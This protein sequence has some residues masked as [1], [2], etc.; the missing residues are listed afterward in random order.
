M[1]GLA[2]LPRFRVQRAV[3]EALA[4]DLGDAGDITTR[5]TVPADA[6]WLAAI[7]ARK[8]GRIA[9]LD[10]ARAAFA[11]LD[12]E[13]ECDIRIGD[14]EDAQAG[15]T[16]AQ[17]RASAHAL[18]SG[19]RVA[20][21]F[22]GHLSGIATQTARFVDAIRGTGAQICCTR[23]TTP[24]LRAF[25]KYAVRA[26]GGVNHRFGLYDAV[27]IKDNHI[28]AAGGIA[29]AIERARDAAGH[30]V[31]IEVEVDTLDQLKE[32]LAH[33]IDAVLLDNMDLPTLAEAV[34]MAK[35]RAITEA[36]GGVTL[37]TVRGIAETG[38]DLISSGALTHS[39]PAL[40]LGLDFRPG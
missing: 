22:L 14:G 16:V 24:G 31:R 12:P 26:G 35:G 18:L 27:L 20:L 32:A 37:E 23:K 4:E 11:A 7:V 33:D 25:E 30:M 6:R 40:D 9:G 17:I 21:N 34:R 29:A 38:V 39:S 8:A 15:E 10:F 2:S 36:S 19:E 28:L 13:A 1:T 5:A 3:E